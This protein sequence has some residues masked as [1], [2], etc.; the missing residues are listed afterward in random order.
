MKC[1]VV[2][3][4]H[5]E[6]RVVIYAKEEGDLVARIRA[7]TEENHTDFVGY[8]GSEIAQIPL[9]QIYAFVIDDG[10]VQ[11]LCEQA[12]WQL[13]ERLYTIE[14]QLPAHFVKINQSCIVDIRKIARFDTAI[15]GTLKVCLKNG[16][17]DYVSRRQLKHIKERMGIR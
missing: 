5:G 1:E 13:K 10:K 6:E 2:I 8:Q 15:S 7:L 16:Y 17:T 14:Q 4:P 9:S 11:A 3:D 12:H